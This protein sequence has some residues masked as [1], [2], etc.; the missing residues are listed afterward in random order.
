M[1]IIRWKVLF[2]I[3]LS[4]GVDGCTQANG[5]AS[6]SCWGTVEVIE[7]GK[8]INEKN[9]QYSMS[10]SVDLTKRLLTIN[11]NDQ[12]SIVGDVSRNTITANDESGGIGSL[13]RVTGAVNIHF[14]Q[15]RG[16][17]T[18]R[19]VCKPAQKLF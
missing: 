5:D 10:I 8:Q 2:V 12:W 4:A 1:P 15:D 18:F 11:D 9:E 17:K 19:G 13:N 6:L 14:I 7:G 3:A 16:T